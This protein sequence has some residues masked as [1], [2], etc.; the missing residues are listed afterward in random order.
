[1]RSQVIFATVAFLAN[2]AVELLGR[3]VNFPVSLKMLRTREGFSAHI[4]AMTLDFL[5]ARML[6]L[7][8][9]RHRV[10][11]H[12]LLIAHAAAQLF[13][14]VG[15]LG[16]EV[17]VKSVGVWEGLLTSHAFVDEALQLLEVIDDHVG[18]RVSA[19]L[20]CF[21]AARTGVEIL[22]V[23][24]GG[25]SSFAVVF[26]L[27]VAELHFVAIRRNDLI[28]ILAFVLVNLAF[29][30]LMQ[31][32]IRGSVQADLQRIKKVQFRLD[33]DLVEGRCHQMLI[34]MRSEGS[35]SSISSVANFAH[36]NETI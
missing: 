1:M 12:K 22:F 3:E 33:V 14:F 24:I 4:A 27:R 35:D 36:G 6:M 7:H 11:P 8:V 29:Q 2:R 26:R 25:L 5:R 10:E 34:E 32:L 15:A 31:V 20:E 13:C 18:L 23:L 21:G 28:K 30:I 17:L 19:P 16:F 9:T